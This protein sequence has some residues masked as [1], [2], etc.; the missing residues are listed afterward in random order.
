MLARRP[1]ITETILT[2]AS[3]GN[4]AKAFAHSCSVY[5]I[6]VIIVI[7]ESALQ[8]LHFKGPIGPTVKIVA[9]KGG[10]YYDAIRFASELTK[11]PAFDS[12]GGVRNVGRRD[13]LGTVLFS[14]YEVMGRVPDY[15]FQAIGSGTGAIAVHEAGKRLN[16]N[17]EP[18]PRLF[19]S[20]N[21]PFDRIC[22]SWKLRQ[23]TFIQFDEME[24]KRRQALMAA[25][26]LAN[27]APPYAV[28]GGLYDAL[29]ESRGDVVSVTNSDARKAADL[30]LRNEHIDLDPA[31]SV[32]LASL[33]QAVEKDS[34]NK[35]AY[36]LLNLTGGGHRKI[37]SEA[38]MAKRADVVIGASEISNERSIEMVEKIAFELLSRP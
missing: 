8:S 26:V 29:S 21:A 4:T 18:G 5:S 32:A 19:L 15:Y 38:V 30:F 9:I 6:P 14:A 16:K 23:R 11:R 25:S 34:I 1:T 28:R 33:I 37:A 12:E 27:R 36:V 10:D 13:G 24:A 20:Q 22:E 35:D 2:V 17:M 7:P 31:A 3:A